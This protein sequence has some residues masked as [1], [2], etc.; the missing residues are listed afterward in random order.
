[1][2]TILTKENLNRLISEKTRKVNKI[3][4]DEDAPS[5]SD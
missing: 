3:T 2:L 1:M 5:F 4:E